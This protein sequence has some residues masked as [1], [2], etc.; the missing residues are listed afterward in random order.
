MAESEPFF[1]ME[2]HA[3][4]LYGPV[5]TKRKARTRKMEFVGW[6]SRPLIE[7]LES[8]GK[9]TSNQISQ[10]DVT[11]II[12]KYVN[13]HNLHHPTKKK[14]ILCDERLLTLFGRKTVARI[15]IYEML[16]SHFAE[17]QVDS[18]DDFLYSSEEEDSACERQKKLTSE[19][20]TYS[21]KKVL[22]APKSCFAAIIPDNIKL[23]YLKRSLVQDLLKEPEA[24]E[25]KIVG[26]F[27][28]IKSDPNDYLQKNSHMLVQVTGLKKVSES[29]DKGAE[30]V[31]QVS[32]F[33][34][35][36]RISMLSDDNFSEAECEDL[37]QRIKD[38]L[39]K[40]PTVVE[41][42]EKVH[43]LHQD[44]TNH[45]LLGELALL[46][47]LIDRANEK[48][49]RK[50]LF[51]YLERRQLLQSP[52]EKSRLLR[53]VPKIIADEIEVETTSQD[54]PA[55]MEE[56]NHVPSEPVS[57]EGAEIHIRD[58]VAKSTPSAWISFDMDST[59]NKAAFAT[60]KQ[61][62]R[63]NE[64]KQPTEVDH[65]SNGK[66][67]PTNAQEPPQ[68]EQKQPTEVDR[69]SSG[70]TQPMNAQ[71]RPQDEQ[72]QPTEIDR[73]SNAKMQPMHAQE[74]PQDERK[75]PTESD[76]ESNA[77]MQPMNAAQRPQG[78]T[79]IEVI[80]LS[81]DEEDEDS[82][83]EAQILDDDEES[84]IW[85]YEDPQGDIQGPF[86]ISSLKRWYDADYFPPDFK[87]WQEGQSQREGVLL[88]DVLRETYPH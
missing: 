41:L 34:K 80:D 19:R 25:G 30:V 11:A 7:F 51:E 42:E 79:V 8:I 14:R 26:S 18:D 85:Y 31:L 63:M 33:M 69:E 5:G 52:D 88:T 10:Y 83:G 54:C 86:P 57:N 55:N 72:K 78:V 76:H 59:G 47:K 67:E 3:G 40:R 82:G 13:D 60:S 44:I 24:F 16:G 45:W 17:N 50:E 75:Q 64:Q 12:N 61:N 32:N 65:E 35:D 53:E 66:M 23:V 81:S 46:Q 73:G 4:Q 2:E 36:V 15:K 62:K 68:D 29:N 48:G 84:C 43:V 20:K 6:G 71:E 37:H 21:K 38:G 28:R 56:G 87:I 70:K 49:W 1:W 27:V 74:R 77:K 9:D 58:I 39:L 22:E